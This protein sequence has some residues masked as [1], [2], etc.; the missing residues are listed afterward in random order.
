MKVIKTLTA[1]VLT[2]A[3]LAG[4]LTALAAEK[5]NAKP[6]PY[7]LDTC[8]VSGEKLGGMGE[9]FVFV[10][11]G[12]EIK[13]CCKGCQKDFKKEPAKF[14]KKLETEQKEKGKKK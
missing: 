4:P 11:E 5:Q 6:K 9:P 10:H 3:I 2:T 1:L 12:Q 13:L 14:M 7:P 8:L